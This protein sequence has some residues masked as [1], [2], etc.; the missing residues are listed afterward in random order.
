MK[1][2]QII[3]ILV[4]VLSL[5]SLG[6]VVAVFGSDNG[7][8]Q[9]QDDYTSLREYQSN[10]AGNTGNNKD[11]SV[12][13]QENFAVADTAKEI[14]QKDFQNSVR[15]KIDSLREENRYSEDNPLVIYNPFQTNTQSLYVYFETAT[16][17]TVSYSVH[18]PNSE[19]ADFGGYV[20]PR[21][22]WVTN[23]EGESI[24]VGTSQIHEFQITGLMPEENNMITIRLT[25]QNGIVK[26][27]RFYYQNDNK[28]GATN[29]T[30]NKEAGTK[31][32][33]N[34]EDGTTTTV[35]A[36]EETLSEGMFVV[37]PGANEI[38]P[39]LRMYDNAGLQRTEIP[40]VQYG[41]GRLL[42]KDGLIYYQVSDTLIAGVDELGQAVKLFSTEPYRMGEDYIFD[43]DG[44]L[45]VLASDTRQTS[46][47]DCVL[48]IN[49]DTGE[50]TELVDMGDLLPEYRAMAAPSDGKL[51]W[52]GLASI[53]WI[54]DNMVLLTAKTSNTIIKLRR[55]YN[56]PRIVFMI[57]ETKDWEKTS[58]LDLFLRSE[59]GEFTMFPGEEFTEFTVFTGLT[60]A[61]SIPYDKIRESRRYI[62]LLNNNAGAEYGKKEEHYSYYDYYVVDEAEQS[63]RLVTRK[64]LPEATKEGS[65]NWYREH[66]IM[67]GG[68]T[69]EFYEY[70]SDLQLI[71]KFTYEEPYVEK[72]V[73]QLD[74]EED[75]PPPDATVWYK[76]VFK[77]DFTDYYFKRE[78]II[79]VPESES[80]NE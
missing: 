8:T 48:A 18:I 39:Y 77:H 70:D 32:L 78:P 73:E 50:V 30:L 14:Y 6:V 3:L 12:P 24:E 17:Y 47:N 69:G 49:T 65:L 71:T 56:D 79:F 22:T 26:V 62:Y 72:T 52:L 37:F 31:Q 74:A 63:V 66:L 19:I 5:L 76:R 80:I 7:E 1:K 28:V 55:L 46:L 2:T 34:E 51:D 53:D 40:L 20:V 16:P 59:G 64:T 13:V 41:V 68:T 61:G 45:L 9:E 42:Q 11:I 29:L 4:A 58:Y 36:S 33:F 57:G 10:N 54:G 75:N 44:N 67:T 35:P 60:Y 43:A 27:R 23:N 15:A 38:Q 21:T 25:D